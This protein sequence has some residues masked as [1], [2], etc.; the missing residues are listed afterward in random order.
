MLAGYEKYEKN[1][2]LFQNITVFVFTR[3]IRI[4]FHAR[5]EYGNVRLNL[6]NYEKLKKSTRVSS[7][8][9]TLSGEG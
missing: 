6:K 7:S 1:T 9:D 4:H 3:K 8:F 5:F 2:M